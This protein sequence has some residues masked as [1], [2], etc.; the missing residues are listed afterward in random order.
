MPAYVR[1]NIG[2]L[3]LVNFIVPMHHVLETVLP[4]HC[5]LW[6]IVTI[7]EQEPRVTFYHLLSFRLLP[8][9]YDC[10]K[11]ICDILRDWKFPCSFTFLF[12]LM[13]NREVYLLAFNHYDLTSNC[14]HLFVFHSYCFSPCIKRLFTTN[15]S[16]SNQ[17]F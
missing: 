1:S 12:L 4:V 10:P 15:T 2:H 6:V 9:F 17:T 7:Q 14:K 3:H 8:I 5:N 16:L 13:K 11:A